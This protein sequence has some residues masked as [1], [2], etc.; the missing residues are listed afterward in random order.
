MPLQNP[1]VADIM[2]ALS[3]MPPDAPFRIDLA[4]ANAKEDVLRVDLDILGHV[5]L[6]GEP[7][8]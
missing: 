6:S 8:Q 3:E 1:T 5:W 4:V 7:I 2:D